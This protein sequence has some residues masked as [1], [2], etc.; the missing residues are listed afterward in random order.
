M[1]EMTSD[2]LADALRCGW[3]AGHRLHGHAAYL[4]WEGTHEAVMT[5]ISLVGRLQP[6]NNGQDTLLDDLHTL[7]SITRKHRI[8][9]F[10]EWL[11]MQP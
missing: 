10:R 9:C 1:F 2:D 11:E 7:L 5:L 8:R 4:Q 6:I 3:Q